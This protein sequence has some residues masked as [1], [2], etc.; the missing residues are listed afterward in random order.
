MSEAQITDD[1]IASLRDDFEI[2]REVPGRHDVYGQGVRIDLVARARP[3]IVESGFTPDWFGIECKWASGG[4][5]ST[6]K[7]TRM[8]WQSITYA[9]STFQVDGADLRLAFVAVFTPDDLPAGIN[10]HL[11][12]LLQLALYGKVGRIYRY[13]DGAWGIKFAK[14]YA[15]SQH[16]VPRVDP[17]Q[18]PGDRV[19][20]V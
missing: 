15:R 6:S 4:G 18:L 8:V 14:I 10:A 9:Q 19:G 11:D 5:G 3:R 16:P 17:C 12:T 2:H 1:L 20:S 7:V 13:K